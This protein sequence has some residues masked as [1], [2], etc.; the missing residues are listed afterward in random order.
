MASSPG[1]IRV[2][3]APVLGDDI[4][5]DLAT[6]PIISSWVSQST[7]SLVEIGPRQV[8]FQGTFHWSIAIVL[9]T[10]STGDATILAALSQLQTALGL[11]TPLITWS[12]PV[13]QGY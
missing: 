8:F 13:T 7:A 2:I 12:F 9:L 1:V 10:T 11:A 5:H 6:H 3:Y 4:S